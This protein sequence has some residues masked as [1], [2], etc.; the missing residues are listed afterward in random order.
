MLR[1]ISYV[2]II[3]GLVLA[4]LGLHSIW[5]SHQAEQQAEE[6]WDT[7]A[8]SQPQQPAKTIHRAG[9]G[10]P[11]AKLS[12]PR[13]DSSWIVVEGA[14]RNELRLGPGHL[15]QTAMPGSRGNCVIAGHRD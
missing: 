2:L 7:L 14:D 5:T 10:E 4:G 15:I 1:A 9:K 12:I 6:Q 11:F 3:A 8:R 13:L